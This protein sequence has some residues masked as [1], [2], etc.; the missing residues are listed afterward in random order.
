[1]YFA[2]LV[3]QLPRIEESR[4]HYDTMLSLDPDAPTRLATFWARI[5]ALVS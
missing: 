3:S 1:M 4:A 2:L 5:K